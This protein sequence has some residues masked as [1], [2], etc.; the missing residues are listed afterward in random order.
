MSL[1]HATNPL[2]VVVSMENQMDAWSGGNCIHLFVP[3]GPCQC[4]SDPF[5]AVVSHEI[6]NGCLAKIK[7]TNQMNIWPTVYIFFA[8]LDNEAP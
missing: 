4:C 6:S 5:I 2:I 7:S 1:L 3:V 8:L